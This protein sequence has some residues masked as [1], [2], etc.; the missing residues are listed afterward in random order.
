LFDSMLCGLVY[1]WS[2]ITAMD[3]MKDGRAG[4]YYL[5]ARILGVCDGRQT[6]VKSYAV[7]DD[8]NEAASCNF[9]GCLLFVVL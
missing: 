4:E 3:F 9:V 1:F 6:S 8:N 7:L 2:E 5:L